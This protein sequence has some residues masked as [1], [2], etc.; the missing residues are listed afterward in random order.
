MEIVCKGI[1]DGRLD[2]IYGCKGTE[3]AEGRMPARSFP[4]EIRD[5]PAGTASYAVIFDDPDSVPV[6]GFKWIH[7]LVS[8]LRSR[9][10]PEDASRTCDDIV[11]GVNSWYPE[12][13]GDR[14]KASC[15]GGPY[16]PDREHI[17]VI[18]VLALDF[19]PVLKKGFTYDELM[20]V[21]KGHVLAT[22]KLNGAYS[23]RNA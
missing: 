21:T 11:Q 16:P 17:Y 1:T 10:L 13:V 5:A 19:I 22:A 2:D 14:M 20:K 9:T 23:P 12:D 8:G 18:T 6:C 7:W 15:Y 3:F 4:L